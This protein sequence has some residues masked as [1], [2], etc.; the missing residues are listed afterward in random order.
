MAHAGTS[1]DPRM[2]KTAEAYLADYSPERVPT[3]AGMAKRMGIHAQRLADW[4]DKHAELADVIKK[5]EQ[6]QQLVLINGML[7]KNA[8]T[9][10]MIFAAKN[11]IGWADRLETHNENMD[12]S[13]RLSQ[14][15]Q[16][17]TKLKAV[18]GGKDKENAEDEAA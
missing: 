17:I 14:A 11:M 16:A 10:G 15:R 7:D 9:P 2:I 18:K 13:S 6:E 3:L 4:Q 12:V 5:C 8:F 1:F